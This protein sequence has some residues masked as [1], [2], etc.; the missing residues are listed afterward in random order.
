MRSDTGRSPA[1][2]L[3]AYAGLPLALGLVVAA[4]FAAL[5]P[6]PTPVENPITEQKR[7]LGKI[8]FFDEQLSASN[9]VACASCHVMNRA[10]SDPRVARNPGVD[11]IFNTPDDLLASPG[12]IHAD[13]TNAYVRDAKFGL[14]PQATGRA[15]NSPIDAAYAPELFW[16]GRAHSQ[17]IDPQTGLTAIANGGAFESQSVNPPASGVK[18]GHDNI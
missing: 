11:N 6:V 1:A 17:F 3:G 12:V 2:M 8:L 9:T 15:A 10:G 14:N 4:A 5:P 18:M 7:I 13:T 16:D